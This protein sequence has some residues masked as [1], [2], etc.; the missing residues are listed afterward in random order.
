MKRDWVIFLKILYWFSSYSFLKTE[1]DKEK[2]YPNF[3][4]ILM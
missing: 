2:V 4:I 1:M 3:K